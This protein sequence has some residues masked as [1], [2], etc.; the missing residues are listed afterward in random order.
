MPE[1]SERREIGDVTL[2]Q[3]RADVIRLSG[4]FMTGEP[5]ALLTEMRA[6]RER[7][8]VAEQGAD[9]GGGGGGVGREG[10]AGGGGVVGA[11]VGER[12]GDGETRG[13]AAR[14]PRTGGAVRTLARSAGRGCG[15][16][17]GSW[18]GRPGAGRVRW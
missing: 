13:R 8:H 2:E 18:R 3:F 5:F 12:V 15:R 4:A 7:M 14:R 9:L 6:L 1:W 10:R 16:P 17:R 11:V